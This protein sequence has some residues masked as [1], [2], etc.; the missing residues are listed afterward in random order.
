[1]IITEKQQKYQN[2]RLEKIDKYEY[3]TGEEIL[4]SNQRQTIIQA[5]FIYF[6]LGKVFEQRIKQI[7]SIA[8]QN[9]RLAALTNKGNHKDICKEIFEKLVKEKFKEIKE[10]T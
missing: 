1:M 4:P 6:P 3:F 5:K 7:G 9:K 2:Y 10:L 8:N